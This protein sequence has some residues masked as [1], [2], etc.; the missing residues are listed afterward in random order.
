[1]AG[2][3][4]LPLQASWVAAIKPMVAAGNT[5]KASAAP[6]NG[7]C[8]TNEIKAMNM[9]NKPPIAS[10]CLKNVLMPCLTHAMPVRAGTTFSEMLEDGAV[11]RDMNGLVV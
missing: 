4:N 1:M 10:G 5:T 11:G 8:D 9:K 2:M 6:I 7:T 3:G